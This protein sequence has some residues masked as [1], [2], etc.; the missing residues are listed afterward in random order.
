MEFP[1]GSDVYSGG[2]TSTELDSLLV[3]E[4]GSLGTKNISQKQDFIDSE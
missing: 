3:C 2:Q 1:S 4:M